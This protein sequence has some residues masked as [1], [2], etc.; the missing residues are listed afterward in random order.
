V[1]GEGLKRLARGGDQV[2]GDTLARFYA[3]HVVAL[4]LIGFALLGVHLFLVQK[5]GMS[6]PEGEADRL[7]GREKVPNMPFVPHFLARDMVGWYLALAIL[8]ALAALFPWELGTKAD[9]FGVAP[10]GIQPEWYFLFMFQTLKKLPEHLFGIEGEVLGVLFFGF[11]GLV[12]LVMPLLDRGEGLRRL[13]VG[14]AAVAVA[15]F[16]VMTSWGWFSVPENATREVVEQA[17]RLRLILGSGLSLGVLIL[18]F[19]FVERGSPARWGLYVLVALSAAIM[20][21]MTAWELLV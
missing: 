17:M 15:F 16:I 18:L 19:P 6:I 1:V 4:P 12:V 14:L 11:C 5:H 21:A 13:L 3:L 20:A 8:A 2:T 9:P 10:A 7:G